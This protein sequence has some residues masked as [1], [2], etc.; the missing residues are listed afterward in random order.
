MGGWFKIYNCVKCKN[1]LTYNQVMYNNGVC[2]KCGF[3]SVSTICD[4]HSIIAKR[5]LCGK[6]WEFWKTKLI[7]KV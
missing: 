1:E 7:Y 2:P 4:T 6:W 5:V 3:D